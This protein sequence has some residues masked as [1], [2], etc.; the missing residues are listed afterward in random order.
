MKFRDISVPKKLVLVFSAVGLVALLMGAVSI[1]ASNMAAQRGIEV[2]VRLAPLG[3]AAMEIKLTATL[4]HLIFEE[5]M[6]GDAR[7][8]IDEVWALLDDSRFYANAILYG[9]QNDE[10]TFIATESPIVR[11]NVEQVLEGIELFVEAARSRYAAQATGQGAASAADAEFDALYDG[12]AGRIAAAALPVRDDAVVQALAGDARYEL[13]H[14]HLLVEEI[15]GGDTSEDFSEATGS[16]EAAAAALERAAR[17]NPVF[18][19]RAAGIAEDIARLTELAGQRYEISMNT[20]GAGSD[21][22][23]AFDATFVGFI[24]A[25]DAAEG[26]IQDAMARGIEEL[27]WSRTVAWGAPVTGVLLLMVMLVFGCRVLGVVLGQRLVELADTMRSLTRGELTVEVPQWPSR[28]ETGEMA[29]AVQVFKDN[30]IRMGEL[31]ADRKESDERRAAERRAMMSELQ[32]AFG[33]VVD[34]A[35]AGDFARRVEVRFDDSELNTLADGVNKLV[36]TVD[37]GLG[38]TVGVMAALADGDLTK[39]MV[40]DYQGSFLKLKEDANRM[41]G[42]IGDIVGRIS[43]ATGSVRSAAGEIDSG[44]SELSTRTES[45]AA[46]LEETAAAMEEIAATVKTNAENAVEANNLAEATR[47]QAERGREVVAETVVAMANIRESSTEIGDIVSTIEGIAFQTNLLAL[48]AAVEAA[49]AGDAGKGFAVVASE[50]RTLAQRSGEAAKTIKD[51]IGKSTGHVEAGERLVGDTD[52]ALAE[53]LEGVRNLAR[54]VEEIADASKE[55]TTGVEEVS[56]TV[57]QMDEMTQQNASMADRSAAAARG[58]TEQSETLVELVRF[59]TIGDASGSGSGA[60]TGADRD[61]QTWDGDAKA[62]TEA[63]RKPAPAPRAAQAGNG[64]AWGE[65]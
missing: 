19:A 20:T 61:Q 4:A 26:A 53:I 43:A 36:E 15:L 18:A 56:G 23:E 13:A 39:R 22:E 35:V 65:F 52:A 25:A 57:S 33:T 3:D 50:V 34:A 27:R 9:A 55:Q 63:A 46:S 8:S 44:A 6:S 54:T 64:G 24:E 37:R 12:L 16:F 10:G 51:L 59:F 31:E 29:R 45:Q 32:D 14:G 40:G 5:I 1:W 49:R 2:G 58:L 60:G 42:Q 62:E 30:A 11:K 47:G 48:N 28:D 7:E 38:E 21:A 41:A 17:A